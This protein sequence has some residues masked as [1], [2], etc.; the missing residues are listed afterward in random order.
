MVCGDIVHVLDRYQLAVG[1]VK[2]VAASG[3]LAEQVPGGAVGTVVGDIAVGGAVVDR[4]TA[5]VGNGEDIKQLLQVGSMVLVVAPGDGQRGLPV[6]RLLGGGV[7]VGAKERDGG[8]VIMEFVEVQGELAHDVTDEVQ[9][10]GRPVAAKEGRQTAAGAIVVE[11]ADGHGR[12]AQ[13]VGI[14]TGG[15]LAQAIEGFPRQE[16]VPDENEQAAGNRQFAAAVLVGQVCIQDLFE[17]HPLKE[18]IEDG[19]G[20]EGTGTQG[21]LRQV[22][23]GSPV[24]LRRGRGSS[25][26]PLRHERLLRDG[27]QRY[28]AA[29]SCRRSGRR[30]TVYITIRSV[31]GKVKAKK[32]KSDLRKFSVA[33][34][35]KP[36]K[37]HPANS[38]CAAQRYKSY[39]GATN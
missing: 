34:R 23:Q 17:V 1:H 14:V 32:T 7:R 8:G 28:G 5:V 31:Y 37:I 38:K 2:K 25:R 29:A 26:F 39:K 27:S 24:R 15:P 9:D 11:E 35:Y 20:P 36:T 12:E 18:V 30:V 16:Q 4:H 19:Q 3:D 10:E 6:A 33:A 22:S 13:C 21:S